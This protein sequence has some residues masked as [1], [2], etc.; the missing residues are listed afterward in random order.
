MRKYNLSRNLRFYNHKWRSF[1]FATVI[2]F[3][4]LK[5]VIVS[6]ISRKVG[7]QVLRD[8]ICRERIDS[9]SKS[10]HII[11]AFWFFGNWFSHKKIQHYAPLKPTTSFPVEKM[12]KETKEE[13][14]RKTNIR[15]G[16]V[17][18]SKVRYME[19]KNREGRIRRTRKEVVGCSQ[20]VM[21][22]KKFLVKFK[23]GHMREMVSCS[24]SYV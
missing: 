11:F 16:S 8:L 24:L 21:G 14:Q 1:N 9:F 13:K 7:P 4:F 22:K 2:P 23:I 12:M 18:T 5:Y 15:V 6:D 17:V 20:A 19:E 10:G 3:L